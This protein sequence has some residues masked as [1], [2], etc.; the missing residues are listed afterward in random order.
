MKV[1]AVALLF[2]ALFATFEARIDWVPDSDSAEEVAPAEFNNELD[3]NEFDW[4]ARSK[5]E[6]TIV[7][8]ISMNFLTD[9]L[10]RIF[11]II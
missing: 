3:F 10:L 6:S 2:C 1:F 5:I 7:G 4:L 11:Y 8:S 9:H